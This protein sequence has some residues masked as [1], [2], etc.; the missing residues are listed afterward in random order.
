LAGANKLNQVTMKNHILVLIAII[1]CLAGVYRAFNDSIKEEFR[2]LWESFFTKFQNSNYVQWTTQINKLF[3]SSFDFIYRS[4]NNWLHFSIWLIIIFSYITFLVARVILYFSHVN[5][6]PT[7][8]MLLTIL[9]TGIG[10]A[11][12]LSFLFYISQ[13]VNLEASVKD[14]FLKSNNIF[15]KKTLGMVAIGTIGIYLFTFSAIQ[16]CILLGATKN[17]ASEISLGYA[18]GPTALLLTL[19]LPINRL[20]ISPIKSFISS[21]FFMLLLG[22][23]FRDASYSLIKE[24]LDG[25]RFILLF[26][27]FNLYADALS[28]IETRF[29][30]KYAQNKKLIALFSLLIIDL[31]F[32]G[33]LFAILP[34]ITDVKLNAFWDGILFKGVNPWFGI[35]FW[36][37]FA[38]SILYYIFMISCICL[39]IIYPVIK[40]ITFLDKSIIRLKNDPLL[41]I[42][43]ICIIFS[44]ILI[45][46]HFIIQAFN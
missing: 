29:V 38:T 36:S 33:S 1:A 44:I 32:S 26:I 13:F 41:S 17:F 12:I 16:F 45:G 3:I 11:M 40:S 5:I 6:P 22:L 24:F 10:G 15:N 35:L 9:L 30:L 19:L 46:G 2:N 20:N 28:L 8:M 37:S 23:V 14:P 25:N 27:L 7:E 31:I 39:A 34:M 42:I 18:L 43:L 21:L 4:N